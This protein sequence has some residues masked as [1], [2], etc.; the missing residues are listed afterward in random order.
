[1]GITPLLVKSHEHYQAVFWVCERALLVSLRWRSVILWSSFS[2]SQCSC[3]GFWVVCEQKAAAV[4]PLS[5]FVIIFYWRT[6]SC[7][8]FCLAT[9]SA[10]RRVRPVI[11][12]AKGRC[13]RSL[14]TTT[15]ANSGEQLFSCLRRRLRLMAGRSIFLSFPPPGIAGGTAAD[16][17]R[18]RN[19]TVIQFC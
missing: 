17:G 19:L 3:V 11:I 7:C 10:Y 18:F 13:H 12:S 14:R 6:G 8:F 9:H 2:N 15:Y 16:S 4:H 5:A 1:M